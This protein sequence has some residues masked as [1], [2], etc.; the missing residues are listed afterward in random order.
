MTSL[1]SNCRLIYQTLVGGVLALSR[2]TVKT[3]NGYTN[4]LYGW[5]AEDDDLSER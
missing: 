3:V 1:R 5:G 2:D 4:M